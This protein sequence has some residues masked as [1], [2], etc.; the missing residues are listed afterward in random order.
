MS[1]REIVIFEKFYIK[2][3]RK[4]LLKW[5]AEN[6]KNFPWRNTENKWHALLA[7]ML[8][9]RTRVKA[10]VPVYRELIEKYP[11]II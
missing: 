4:I 9:Q 3:I 6:Y 10:V 2:K 5:G 1:E 11:E 7:E 8:L